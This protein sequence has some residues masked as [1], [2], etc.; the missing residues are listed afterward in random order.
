[1]TG[2]WLQSNPLYVELRMRELLAEAEQDRLGRRARVDR[3]LRY[4]LGALLIS[5][6]E[7]LAGP[8]RATSAAAE[9]PYQR[10][11]PA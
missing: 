6:G 1:M 11:A 9:S 4:R 2:P 7:A 10:R 5:A 8:A 3:S